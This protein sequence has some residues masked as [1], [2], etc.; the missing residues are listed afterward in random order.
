MKASEV[1]GLSIW[2]FADELQKRDIT[3]NV[4]LGAVGGN[5]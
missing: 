4:S 2:E 3:V 1:A 5:Y